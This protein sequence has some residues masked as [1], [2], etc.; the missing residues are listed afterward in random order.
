MRHLAEKNETH[1]R[2]Y[3]VTK[4]IG[5]KYIFVIYLYLNKNQRKKNVYKITNRKEYYLIFVQLLPK[6]KYL[7]F[8]KKSRLMISVKKGKRRLGR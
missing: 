8:K 7:K 1:F 2:V 5:K 6:Y 3:P 4:T